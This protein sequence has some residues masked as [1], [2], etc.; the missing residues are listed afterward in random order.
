MGLYE[1]AMRVCVSLIVLLF[2]TSIALVLLR[3]AITA[4]PGIDTAIGIGLLGYVI[5]QISRGL[6]RFAPKRDGRRHAS[7][8]ELPARAQWLGRR[9]EQTRRTSR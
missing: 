1:K 6:R 9:Q 4:R 2:V 5:W 3:G 7:A 8:P